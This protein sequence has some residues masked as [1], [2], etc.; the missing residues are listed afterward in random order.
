MKVGGGDKTIQRCNTA[1][2]LVVYYAITLPRKPLL[3]SLSSRQY[4]DV[5]KYYLMKQ[6]FLLPKKKEEK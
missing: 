1:I 5:V 3:S 4:N 6:T 2:L